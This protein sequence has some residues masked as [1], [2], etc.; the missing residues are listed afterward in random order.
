MLHK[1][2]DSKRSVAKKNSGREPRGARRQDE[3]IGRREVGGDEKWTQYL[4]V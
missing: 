3:L 4:E 2:Y 1:D